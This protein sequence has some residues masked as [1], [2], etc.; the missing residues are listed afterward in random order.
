MVP[1]TSLLVPIVLSAV[2][3][4]LASFI[5]HMVLP[6]HRKDL[7]KFPKE[8]E[9]MEVLRRFDAP[10]G[11]YALPYAGS[12]A[13][14]KKPEFI[15]KINKGPLV[16]MTL[17]RGGSFSMGKNL[18]LWFLF[19]ALISFFAAYVTGRAVGVGTHYLVIFRF[20]GTISFM[21]YSFGLLQNSIWYR[22]NWCATL[23]SVFDGL[24]YGLLT[25]GTFGW[26]WP[27]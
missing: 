19:S 21:A 6:F 1:L 7:R 23:R 8:D 2:I 20:V 5:I 17:A 27:R 10:P 22:R 14:M 26:L 11:D 18:V 25:A 9:L 4:F 16:L 12:P 24:I 15:D 13:G 3:V